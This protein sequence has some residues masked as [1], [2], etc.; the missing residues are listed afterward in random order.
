[1]AT[2]S[3]SPPEGFVLDQPQQQPQQQSGMNLPPGFVVDHQQTATRSAIDRF[4]RSFV[5]AMGIPESVQ[6]N[7]SEALTGLK[8]AVQHPGLLMDSLKAMGHSLVDAQSNLADQGINQ[9]Q[10]PGIVNKLGGATRVALSGVPVLGPALQQSADQIDKGNVAGGLGTAAAIFAPMV[11]ASPAGPAMVDAATSLPKVITTG[12]GMLSAR[13]A[14]TPVGSQFSRQAV[15]NDAQAHGVNLDLAQATDSGVLNAAKRANRYSLAASG[16][17]DAAATKNLNALGE[18]ADQEASRYSPPTGGREAVGPMI[19][20]ALKN[21][22][23]DQKSDASHAFEDLDTRVGSASVDATNTLQAEAQKII[24]EN[25]PYYDKHPEMLPK[26]AWA[27]VQ[28][29]AKQPTV[30]KEVPGTAG[31]PGLIGANGEPVQAGAVK[32]ISEPIP[33]AMSWSELHQLRSDLMDFYRN[34]PDVI[35]GRA[36]SWIQRLVAKTDDAMTGAASSL[37]PSDLQK[38]RQANS[39]WEG[40][41]GTFDNP[42]HPFYQAVRSQFPSQVPKMLSSG[43]PE[44]ATAVRDALGDLQGPFQR[45]F[46]ETLLNGKDGQTLD[47][48]GLDARL[49]RLPQDHLEAML[50][51]EGA[52]SLRMLG[53]VA[54]KV[55]ADANP[56]GTAKVGVPAAEVTGLFHNP[57]AGVAELGAQYTGA[58]LMNSPGMVD[59]LTRNPQPPRTAPPATM[60]KWLNARQAQMRAAGTSE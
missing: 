48:G 55:T 15:L 8:L 2:G 29:L 51:P 49:K 52:D 43:T 33:K 30:E 56:S 28:D 16:T 35:K 5:S 46:V 21:Q 59:W 47:L 40:I 25:K 53:R 6:D 54:Q 18:W 20:A 7:P 12:E 45:Q 3:V 41:K 42:Q 23:E 37:S 24:D 57:I 11:A 31:E 50:G 22:L 39:T 9:M 38:F 60:V 27:V 36:D 26:Q 14:E 19:Q 32:T 34:N 44:L 1:M 17:Y 13:M 10:Q 58:K 4:T